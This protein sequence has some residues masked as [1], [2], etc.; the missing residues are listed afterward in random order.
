MEKQYEFEVMLHSMKLEKRWLM[1]GGGVGIASI[2]GVSLWVYQKYCLKKEEIVSSYIQK[3]KANYE[4][5]LK[6]HKHST[7]NTY[8]VNANRYIDEMNSKI[9]RYIYRGRN[10]DRLFRQINENR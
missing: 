9:Q 8:S 1:I 3:M 4:K 7:K 2:L 10:L 5:S 6:F